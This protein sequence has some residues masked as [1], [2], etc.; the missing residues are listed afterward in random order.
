MVL[1]VGLDKLCPQA[2]L[3]SMPF[4]GLMLQRASCKALG[5]LCGPPDRLLDA[6]WVLSAASWRLVEVSRRLLGTLSG[7]LEP[8]WTRPGASWNHCGGI[9]G[10]PGAVW[11]AS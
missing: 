7:I 2:S 8:S 1:A 10:A 11:E 9:L 6:F 4:G 5:D 3:A